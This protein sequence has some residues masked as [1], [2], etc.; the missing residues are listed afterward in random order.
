MDLN[1][2]IQSRSRKYGLIFGFWALVAVVEAAQNYASQFVM[3][4]HTFPW[5]LAFRRAFEEWYPWAFLSV[6]ILDC[7]RRVQQAELRF[8]RPRSAVEQLGAKAWTL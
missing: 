1:V 4:N 8:V 3:E 7:S 2:F 5:G 6:L